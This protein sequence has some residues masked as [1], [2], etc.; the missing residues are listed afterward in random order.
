MAPKN[1]AVDA[2]IAK[3]L[4]FARPILRR[5]RTVAHKACPKVEETLKWGAPHFQCEGGLFSMAA[6]KEHCSVTFGKPEL[7]PDPKRVLQLKDRTA[8][9]HFGRVASL[10]D[11]PATPVLTDLVKHAVRVNQAGLKSTR[12]VKKRA[13][14]PMPAYFRAALEKSKKAL[15]TWESFSPSC[16]R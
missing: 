16:K 3:S 10:K 6:F 1:P 15:A 12:V 5:L 2:Y 14:I 9:G 11:L 13:A 4:P 8:M 7:L